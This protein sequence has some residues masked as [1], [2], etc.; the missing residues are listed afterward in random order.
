MK[1]A[2]EEGEGA[3]LPD[4][5]GGGGGGDFPG[6]DTGGGDAADV[7]DDDTGGAD[8]TDEPVD[9]EEPGEEPEA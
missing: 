2:G 8:L 7:G 3:E 1:G 9:F 6:D 4:T 5:G